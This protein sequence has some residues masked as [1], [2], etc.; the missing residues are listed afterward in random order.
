MY[1]VKEGH[2][3]NIYTH[4]EKEKKIKIN[5]KFNK[6]YNKTALKFTYCNNKIAS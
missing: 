5:N 4:I 2:K 6:G 3:Q 1:D